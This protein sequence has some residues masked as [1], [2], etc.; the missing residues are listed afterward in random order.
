[1]RRTAGWCAALTL[2]GCGATVQQLKTR[3]SMDLDCAPAQLDVKEIDPGTRQVEG[4]GRRAMYVQIFNN[5]R[6]PA[7]MLNS[8]IRDVQPRSASR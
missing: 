2:A 1:M 4:C 8:A 3:A 5:S 6:Y 7:W